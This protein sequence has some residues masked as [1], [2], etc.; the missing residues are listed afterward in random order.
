MF[1]AGEISRAEWAAA[2]D[3]LQA[4]VVAANEEM[5]NASLSAATASLVGSGASLR[6]RWP[7]LSLGQRRAVVDAVIESI[8]I[9]PTTRAGNKFDPDR[10]AVSWRV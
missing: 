10:V 7:D 8:T 6:E 5:N 3:A 2:R 4:R 9:A 1:A